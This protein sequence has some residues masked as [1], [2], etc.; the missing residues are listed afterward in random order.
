MKIYGMMLA[1]AAIFFGGCVSYEQLLTNIDKAESWKGKVEF[2][3]DYVRAGKG[4][5]FVLYGK[6]PTPLV[7]KEFIPVEPDKTYVYKVNFRTL[8]PELPASG[9][10]GLELYDADKRIIGHYNVQAYA[11]TESEVVSARKGDKFMIVKMIKGYE[12]IKYSAV[13]FNIKKD[14]S[15]LPNY[16]IS[17]QCFKMSPDQDGNL[18]LEFKAPL[19]KDYP[20]GTP[21]RIHS[22][23]SPSMYYLASGWMPEGE[24]KECTAIL[25]GIK[26]DAG[27]S[28]K[29]FW[30]GTKYVRPFVWFGNWNRR[31][32]KG[33]K[34]LVDG[35]SFEATD[36]IIGK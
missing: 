4:P 1:A 7:Y 35:W 24:G 30:K 14:Y 9:Y 6:Y 31:P 13:A 29:Q 19:K 26:N 25:R 33:A 11:N 15:D 8:D 17:P 12:K 10:M 3:T 20:A 27:T 36:A 34:L 5:C 28:A 21:V 16:D 2:A 22:P 32:K 18:R 23:W